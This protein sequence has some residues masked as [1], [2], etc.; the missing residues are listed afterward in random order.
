MD[1]QDKVLVLSTSGSPKQILKSSKVI[2]IL[3]CSNGLIGVVS[4]QHIQLISV[5]N[6]ELIGEFQLIASKN[7][8]IL[9]A[10]CT[11]LGAFVVSTT[12]GLHTLHETESGWRISSQE[13]ARPGQVFA[14]GANIVLMSTSTVALLHSRCKHS[15]MTGYIAM[16]NETRSA[17]YLTP[18]SQSFGIGMQ[19]HPTGVLRNLSLIQ[20]GV[21]IATFDKGITI[22]NTQTFQTAQVSGGY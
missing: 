15:A 17:V 11:L 1:D 12:H 20:S 16:H 22:L 5:N 8:Y 13:L 9:S 10:C 21:I 4:D 7:E 14:A 2:R 3:I 6:G 18:S 19:L